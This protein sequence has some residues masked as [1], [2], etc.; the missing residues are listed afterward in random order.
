M[1]FDSNQHIYVDIII[2]RSQSDKMFLHTILSRRIVRSSKF[3][4]VAKFLYLNKTAVAPC[5]RAY[6]NAQ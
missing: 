1:I 6:T 5:S 2:L 4:F 3:P